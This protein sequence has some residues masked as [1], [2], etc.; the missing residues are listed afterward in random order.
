MPPRDVVLLAQHVAVQLNEYHELGLA[1]G[2]FCISDVTVSGSLMPPKGPATDAAR[3]ADVLSIAGMIWELLT[4]TTPPAPSDFSEA[5]PE[6]WSRVIRHLLEEC[7]R[8]EAAF[9][10][11]ASDVASILEHAPALMEEAQPLS[12][13]W[14]TPA[15]LRDLLR[16]LEPCGVGVEREQRSSSI[17]SLIVRRGPEELEVSPF[18][19][20]G[21]FSVHSRVTVGQLTT[22]LATAGGFS[23]TD[24]LGL[25]VVSRAA[26]PPL[27]LDSTEA[28][29]AAEG[30]VAVDTLVLS[31]RYDPEHHKPCEQL[32]R[33]LHPLHPTSQPLCPRSTHGLTTNDHQVAKA[34]A[35][36]APVGG[37]ANHCVLRKISYLYED[38]TELWTTGSYSH[39][40]PTYRV[41]SCL[42][43]AELKAS[44]ATAVGLP[45]P[46]S[47]VS[48]EA[49]P[50]PG[51]PCRKIRLQECHLLCAAS[52]SARRVLSDAKT[53]E[54]EML[55]FAHVYL[56]LDFA[57]P[58]IESIGTTID[59]KNRQE[60]QRPLEVQVGFGGP[61]L[62]VTADESDGVEHLKAKLGAI[63]GAPPK[64]QSLFVG[65]TEMEDGRLV[66]QYDL[67]AQPLMLWH[68]L[69][70]GMQIFVKLLTG[71]TTTLEVEPSDSIDSVKVKIQEKAGIPPDQQRVIFA[72]KQLEDGRT[73]SDY[74]IQKESTLHLVLRLRGT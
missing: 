61:I 72:G 65:G 35:D 25:A 7:S 69:R 55:R 46:S 16:A 8:E 50:L 52:P 10:P 28:T 54:E 40:T 13:S 48:V 41:R 74:N 59:V 22:A 12:L 24:V 73:L 32:H 62:S 45:S 53:L 30:V 39:G 1:H 43:V 20:E 4:G 60:F 63:I 23:Q 47:V 31:L 5:I 66:A 21:P 9:R 29:L 26:A 44:L 71:I 11:S 36:L 15:A 57:P 67:D 51:D 64:R 19:N 18:G 70:G 33:K 3:A 17:D 38:G 14:Y 6:S 34:I 56:T 49:M 2:G 68:R 37:E 58:S 42:T 27:P